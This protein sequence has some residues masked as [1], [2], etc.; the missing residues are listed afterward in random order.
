[1]LQRN[2]GAWRAWYDSE[3]PERQ[4]IPDYND[5]LTKFERMCIVKVACASMGNP[6]VLAIVNAVSFMALCI[7]SESV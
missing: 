3:D 1:M 7:D 2:E 6:S 5:K 4:R